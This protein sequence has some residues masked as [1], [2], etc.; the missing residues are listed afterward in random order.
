MLMRAMY[1]YRLKIYDI[2]VV[3]NQLKE[4]K[5]KIYQLKKIDDYTYTFFASIYAKKRLKIFFPS[6][7]IV[8]RAGIFSIFLSLIQYKTTL[9]A[10]VLSTAFYI[11]CASR[12]WKIN[13][14]GDSERLNSLIYEQLNKN[15]IKVGNKV[16][17]V[18]R[19]SAIQSKILY[20]NY[21]QIEYLSIQQKGCVIEVS[22]RKKRE[23]TEQT[24]KGGNLYAT[25]DGMIKSFNLLSGEKV[26]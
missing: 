12:I 2:S 9:I 22:F 13:V 23:K 14:T 10:L 19:L 6:I 26:V 8:K 16:L 21:D 3:L 11:I 1:L 4:Q 25:K 17:D 24:I 5:I 20:E 7:E 15:D 18:N